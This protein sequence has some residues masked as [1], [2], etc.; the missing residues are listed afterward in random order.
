MARFRRG[1]AHSALLML[2]AGRVLGPVLPYFLSLAAGAKI[3]VVS[4][5]S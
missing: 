3:Y 1:G 4:G 5:R 2:V